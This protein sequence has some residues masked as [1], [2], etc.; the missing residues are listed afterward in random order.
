V[1]G[2]LR[3]PPWLVQDVLAAGPRG[4]WVATAG[5]ALLDVVPA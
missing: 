4:V 2:W 5:P 1:A 3:G